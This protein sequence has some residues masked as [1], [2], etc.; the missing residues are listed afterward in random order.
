MQMWMYIIAA[1]IASLIAYYAYSWYYGVPKTD[2]EQQIEDSQYDQGGQ[3]GQGGIT[4]EN[5]E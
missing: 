4:D 1:I 2:Y 5:T 3:D